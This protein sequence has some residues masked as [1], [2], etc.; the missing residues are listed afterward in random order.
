MKASLRWLRE[1]LPALTLSADEVRAQLTALGLEVEG[2]LEFG[3][4]LEAVRVAEVVAI[5]P[6]PSRAQLSLVTVSL[7]A[8]TQRVV[9]GATNVPAPGG[10]V[11]LAPLG[12]RLP[13]G[14]IEPRA[15]GGVTSEGMLCSE[16]ELG[17][18]DGDDGIL[19]LPTG[20][21]RAGQPLLE[22][23]PSARDVV[24][25][26]G[27]TPNRPD[28]LGH[29]G[30][31]RDLAASL[32]LPFSPPE[33]AG[34]AA[35]ESSAVRVTIDDA[36]RCPH[37]GAALLRGVVVAPSPM[38]VRH[39]LT[40][41]G[42]RPINNVVDLTNL[43]MLEA[44]HPMHAFD[45][46][47]VSGG[48]IRVRRAAAGE[49]FVTLDGKEHALDPDDLV[50]ADG[51]RAVALAGVMG[52]QNS[53][54][55]AA[56]TTVLLEC[57]YFEPRGVRRAAR[58]H[59]LH[60][61][62]SHRFERGVDPTGVR[63][64][65]ARAERELVA[66]AG[67]EL[68]GERHAEPAPFVPRRVTLRSARL[69]ALLGVAVPF[70][71]ARALLA[72][73]GCRE[74]EGD[75]A[76]ATFEAPGHRPDLVREADLIEEVARL[77]G[78][79]A[80]PVRLPSI[81]PRTREGSPTVDRL[82]G[83]AVELGLSEAITFAFLSPDDLSRARADASSVSL[84]NPMS[85]AQGVLRTSLLPGLLSAASRAA[86]HGADS[87]RLFTIG[88]TFHAPP[89]GAT[90]PT[91]RRGLAALLVGHQAERLAPPRP[92]DV[93]DAKGAACELVARATGRAPE[94]RPIDAA[95]R[96]AHHHPR[97]SADL[98]IDG[99]VVGSFAILH[100]DVTAAFEIAP[101]A[102]V[103]ELS[104]DA[105]DAVGIAVPRAAGIPRVPAAL[106]DIALVVHDDVPQSA[107]ASAIARAAGELCEDVVVFDLYRDDAKLGADHRSL[108]FH[109]VY[110]DPRAH[111]ADGAARTLTDAEVDLRHAAVV[112]AVRA[113][114]GASLRG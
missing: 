78:L 109:V 56:T 63:R 80:I 60:T 113:E 14:V 26:I 52:G 89:P 44:G 66:M 10:L 36:E 79:D 23:A 54:I 4:G 48:E 32:G 13:G 96:P 37:Y 73:L 114:L 17:V 42:V 98:S 104:I 20:S 102:V 55:H 11:V 69:D 58:R 43:M 59:G 81:V 76:Q 85:D 18:G 41:L 111:E 46:S 61:D 90:L 8:T 95:R 75:A 19:V 64:V 33:A 108:A 101:G 1:L 45:F 57:A 12:T 49:R 74:L 70:D 5:E 68:V 105:L 71:E 99:R 40:S 24:F 39:R 92:F 51:A 62:S 9:C 35:A 16:R 50:I 29:V 83:V 72:R 94:V 100:P 93:Y 112:A 3:E 34:S 107:V 103:V 106:R 88:A 21:A 82:R 31:A 6:H 38:A 110:R 77:R 87:A 91:E 65:L 84:Q 67:G 7:G 47:R 97:G 2:V 27:V 25:E 15:I 28:A 86:R 53:E 22:A 30:L